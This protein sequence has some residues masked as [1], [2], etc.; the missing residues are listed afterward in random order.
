MGQQVINRQEHETLR[1]M[2]ETAVTGQK[3]AQK[4]S[5]A[6]NKRLFLFQNQIRVVV[7]QL[8]E[9]TRKLQQEQNL[10]KNTNKQE[11]AR[12]IGNTIDTINEV[13]NLL[14]SKTNNV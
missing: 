2:Y 14:A 7:N 3:S 9:K 12:L 6:A 10:A 11:K 4:E 13:I 5:Q 8:Q 1:K